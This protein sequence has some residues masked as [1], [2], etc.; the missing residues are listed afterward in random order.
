MGG[1]LHIVM[2]PIE[3]H[4]WSLKGSQPTL[5]IAPYCICN[6]MAIKYTWQ[7]RVDSENRKGHSCLGSISASRKLVL[8]FF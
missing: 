3:M 6:P 4:P 5:K 2:Y 7:K 8:I 1:Q